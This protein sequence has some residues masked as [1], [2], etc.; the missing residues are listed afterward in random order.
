[1]RFGQE[2]FKQDSGVTELGTGGNSSHYGE[3]RDG[4]T[5]ELGPGSIEFAR[6]IPGADPAPGTL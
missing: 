4:Q 1:M 2:A 5:L 6:F 3:P